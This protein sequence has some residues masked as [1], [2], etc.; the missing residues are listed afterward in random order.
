MTMEPESEKAPV[1]LPSEA[2]GSSIVSTPKAQ[3]GGLSR[4][5]RDAQQ[6]NHNQKEDK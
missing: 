6:F 2:D 4:V 1:A 5:S 3:E